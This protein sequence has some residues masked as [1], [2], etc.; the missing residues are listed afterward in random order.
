[1]C[2]LKL[3]H[4]NSLHV[5]QLNLQSL[6]CFISNAQSASLT[7]PFCPL[8]PGKAGKVAFTHPHAISAHTLLNVNTNTNYHPSNSGNSEPSSCKRTSPNSKISVL[9]GNSALIMWQLVK[10]A[11][12]SRNAYFISYLQ[13]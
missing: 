6:T 2:L 7:L 3:H 5:S 13:C 10:G 1:M 9:P 8:V 11:D 4:L 12:N